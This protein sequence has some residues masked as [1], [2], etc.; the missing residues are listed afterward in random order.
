MVEDALKSTRTLHQLIMTVSLVTLV[1]ALSVSLPEDK[2]NA[3]HHADGGPILI[4]LDQESLGQSTFV[5][6]N[7]IS[8]V[9]WLDSCIR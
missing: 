7:T 5:G 8:T 1:F 3:T 4:M 2:I 6:F 9:S